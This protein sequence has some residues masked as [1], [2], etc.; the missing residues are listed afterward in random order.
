M[1]SHK[2][3]CRK[4]QDLQTKYK[5]TGSNWGSMKRWEMPGTK[6]SKWAP[7]A[8]TNRFM[9]S[10]TC[11]WS[12]QALS[13]RLQLPDHITLWPQSHFIAVTSTG[14]VGSGLEEDLHFSALWNTCKEAE[15]QWQAGRTIFTG[16]LPYRNGVLAQCLSGWKTW[17]RVFPVWGMLQALWLALCALCFPLTL[18][19]SSEKK[20]PSGAAKPRELLLCGCFL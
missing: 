7:S 5:I 4:C 18:F 11:F 20:K 3:S 10:L 1:C 12:P 13:C 15:G 6:E 8:S 2:V 14:E 16:T 9:A 19:C 17:I